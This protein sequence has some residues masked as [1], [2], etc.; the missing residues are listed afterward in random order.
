MFRLAQFRRFNQD[1]NYVSLTYTPVQIVGS[2]VQK[3]V[4]LP[5]KLAAYE[6]GAWFLHNHLLGSRELHWEIEVS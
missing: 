1:F 2:L 3:C 5:H 4:V 6:Q